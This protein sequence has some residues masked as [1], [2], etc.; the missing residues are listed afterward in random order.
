MI[1]KEECTSPKKYLQRLTARGFNAQNCRLDGGNIPE[2]FTVF[3]FLRGH[4]RRLRTSN[5]LDGLS[6][7]IKQCT[8]V[9][10]VFPN[11]QSCL[12]LISAILME[13][14]EELGIGQIIFTDGV[15]IISELNKSVGS[16][17]N[18]SEKKLH[19]LQKGMEFR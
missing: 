8:R 2:G 6:Q 4:Q 17:I 18:F 9:V 12:R 7:E 10:R 16:E 11:E 14:G 3:S 19:N 13:F 15:R 5:C 1:H